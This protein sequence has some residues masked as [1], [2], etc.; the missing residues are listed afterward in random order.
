MTR[1]QLVYKTVIHPTA[2]EFEA[3]LSARST[4]EAGSEE[5]IP[6]FLQVYSILSGSTDGT[7][8]GRRLKR[9]LHGYGTGHGR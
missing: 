8:Q 7:G 6:F 1:F 4:G 3:P 5:T 2:D 9:G